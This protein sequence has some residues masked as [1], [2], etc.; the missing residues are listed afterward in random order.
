M[1][2]PG[3]SFGCEIGGHGAGEWV[4]VCGMGATRA[5]TLQHE[6]RH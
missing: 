6:V 4:I 3:L 1:L 5:S 2:L